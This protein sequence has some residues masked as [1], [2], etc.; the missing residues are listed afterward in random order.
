MYI[1]REQKFHHFVLFSAEIGWCSK[2]GD[3]FSINQ[4]YKFWTDKKNEELIW[5]HS[6]KFVLEICMTKGLFLC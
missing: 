4:I 3:L 2:E 6:E 5:N 1:Y